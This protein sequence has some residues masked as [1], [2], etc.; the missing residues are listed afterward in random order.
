MED[1][2]L[3][4]TA[5]DVFGYILAYMLWFLAIAVA[6][7]AMLEARN[8]LN[9]IWP[10]LGSGV[11]WGWTLRP[12]DRFG[13]VFL[14]LAWLVYELY[15]ENHYRTAIT[16]VRIR[17]YKGKVAPALEDERANWAMRQFARLGL[18]VLA[19]RFAITILPPLA[20][21]LV[22]V[23]VKWVAFRLLLA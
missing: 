20:I 5:R 10:V 11:R 23:L 9:A 17:E 12:V 16:A 3:K 2:K 22:S 8:A 14:G 13:L 15:T 18:D 6:M 7:L 19:P 4:M 21:W 1:I